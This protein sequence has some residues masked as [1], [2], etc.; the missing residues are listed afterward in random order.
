MTLTDNEKK[1]IVDAVK[2]YAQIMRQQGAPASTQAN[3]IAVIQSLMKKMLEPE[4]VDDP[5]LKGLTDE[6]FDNVCLKCDK[7]KNQCT[8]PVAKKY[9]GKCD[10]ILNYHKSAK[11]GSSNSSE[12]GV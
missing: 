2:V 3:T 9:P 8:D 11:E 7:F 5:K 1:L 6:E 4:T 12:E 10:P